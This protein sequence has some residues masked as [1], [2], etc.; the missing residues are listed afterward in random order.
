MKTPNTK[1]QTPN[2]K[3]QTPNTKLQAPKKSQCPNP[4]S[5]SNVGAFELEHWGFSGVWSLMFGVSL[6][7]FGVCPLVNRT[8]TNDEFQMTKETRNPKHEEFTPRMPAGLRSFGLCHSFD[9][10]HS[11]F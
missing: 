4:N 10:R 7:G 5:S 6:V 11:S 2:S 1:L 8:M 3:K 9:I